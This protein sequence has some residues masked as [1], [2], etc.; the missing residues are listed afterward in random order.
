MNK[1]E[2]GFY[3]HYKHDPQGK[4]NNYAY[5]VLGFG[6]HTEIENK[7]DS[8]MV[9]YRPLYP[10][11]FVYQKDKSFYLR[12][13]KMFQENVLIKGEEEIPRFTK[14]KDSKVIKVLNEIRHEMYDE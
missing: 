1:I 10:A 8:Q 9:I 12:P 11:A 13:L 3:Y 4:I 2:R 6:F 14:I 7:E 5:E